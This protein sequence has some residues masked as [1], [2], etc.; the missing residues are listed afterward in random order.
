ME[1]YILSVLILNEDKF[2]KDEV[3]TITKNLKL[4]TKIY[5]ILES[6]KENEND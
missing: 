6:H 5:Q 1:N 4:I 2:D 3:K